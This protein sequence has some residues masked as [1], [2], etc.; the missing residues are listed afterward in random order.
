MVYL[1]NL[2]TCNWLRYDSGELYDII[3]IDIGSKFAHYVK[4]FNRLSSHN[5]YYVSGACPSFY[6]VV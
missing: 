6:L 5:G 3:F 2:Q 1:F 4:T